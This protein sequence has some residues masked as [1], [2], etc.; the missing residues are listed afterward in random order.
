VLAAIAIILAAGTQQAECLPGFPRGTGAQIETIREFAAEFVGGSGELEY[1]LRIRRHEIVRLYV[2]DDGSVRRR[3]IAG[4]VSREQ[5]RPSGDGAPPALA[6][7]TLAAPNERAMPVPTA[8]N[9]LDHVQRGNDYLSLDGKQLPVDRSRRLAGDSITEDRLLAL[10]PE[11]IAANSEWSPKLDAI[12]SFFALRGQLP[13]DLIA[14]L[15]AALEAT[16]RRAKS[17]APSRITLAGPLRGTI[18]LHPSGAPLAIDAGLEA[19]FPVSTRTIEFRAKLTAAVRATVTWA[20]LSDDRIGRI[21]EADWFIRT[22]TVGDYQSLPEDGA[23]KYLDALTLAQEGGREKL[24]EAFRLYRGLLTRDRSWTPSPA[25]AALD[26]WFGRLARKLGYDESSLLAFGLAAGSAANLPLERAETRLLLGATAADDLIADLAAAGGTLEK[27]LETPG[28]HRGRINYLYGR[29]LASKGDWMG[30]SKHF[31]AAAKCATSDLTLYKTWLAI[32]KR[33]LGETDAALK[34]ARSA[35]NLSPTFRP[36]RLLAQECDAAIKR[37][38]DLEIDCDELLCLATY[39]LR[40]R[41]AGDGRPLPAL[42]GLRL[43][44]LGDREIPVRISLSIKDVAADL[45]VET[46][47]PAGAWTEKSLTPELKP[48]VKI[49]RIDVE[50]KAAATLVIRRTDADKILLQLDLPLRLIP[51]FTL[52]WRTTDP[53]LNMP[54]IDRTLSIA[55]WVT[56]MARAVLKALSDAGSDAMSAT[57]SRARARAIFDFVRRRLKIGA[58]PAVTAVGTTTLFSLRL[59]CR[60]LLQGEATPLEAAVLFATLL[61]A[62]GLQPVILNLSGRILVGWRATESETG[63]ASEL[64]I[65]I[66]APPGR[67]FEEAVGAGIAACQARA[68]GVGPRREDVWT[69]D[70][71]A[72]RKAGWQPQPA[73][74]E[75]EKEK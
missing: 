11:K 71:A 29:A 62:A 8:S 30:A 41:S 45:A 18:D 63:G 22:P 42:V 21:P 61:E 70:I 4:F 17:A 59:P 32:A 5:F 74:D 19:T 65:D 6:S 13:N 28:P 14:P 38:L 54:V 7:L 47:I 24:E 36:A 73:G 39:H 50:Q 34:A 43:R 55:A 44:S 16:A 37:G 57:A 66:A 35:I 58:N 64:F 31:E 69:L 23:P 15:R 9:A 51:R 12:E 26:L 49:D 25:F 53:D 10:L 48:A 75:P 27:G 33:E 52:E 1:T 60:T 20:S 2:R 56:P 72:L 40:T 46:T 67:T 68:F 3:V